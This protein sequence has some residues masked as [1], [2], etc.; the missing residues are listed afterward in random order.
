MEA[1]GALKC[2]A[3]VEIGPAPILTTLGQECLGS[4]SATWCASLR[5]GRDDWEQLFDCVMTL[6][7]LGVPIDMAGLEAG[8]PRRRLSLPTYQ[9]QRERYWFNARPPQDISRENEAVG[10][11]PLLGLQLLSPLPQAQFQARLS[12]VTPSFINDHQVNGTVLLP[13]T[14]SLEMARAAARAVF[15]PGSHVVEDLVLRQAMIF[16]GE[17]RRVVQ[18]TVEP[19]EK[20]AS[21][22]RI[23]STPEGSNADWTLHFEGQLRDGAQVTFPEQYE[24]LAAIESRCSA[25]MSAEPI[26]ATVREQGFEFGH[27][28]RVLRT[29]QKGIGEALG[30]V[31]LQTE[32]SREAEAYNIHPVLLDGC[33]QTIAAAL[34]SAKQEADRNA[35]YLPVGVHRFRIFSKPGISCRSHAVVEET[36]RQGVTA[37]RA[38]VRLYH[39]NGELLA[40]LEGIELQRVDP[41]ALQRMAARRG[42]QPM[43]VRRWEPAALASRTEVES[44]QS[45]FVILSDRS[46]IG[47]GLASLLKE[48]GNRCLLWE[49]H[50]VLATT[51]KAADM[52]L[53]CRQW[54]EEFGNKFGVVD[55]RWLDTTE[56]QGS[57]DQPLET[58][59][60]GTL[61]VL[62]AMLADLSDAQPR[63]W[64]VTRGGQPAGEVGS[65]LSPWQSAAWG[66]GWSAALEHPEFRHVRIDLDPAVNSD[67]IAALAAE[68]SQDGAEDQVALRS[69]QRLVARLVRHTEPKEGVV[70]LVKD[71][72]QLVARQKGAI[73]GLETV[74]AVRRAPESGE[75]EIR[76]EASGLNFRDV[77]NALDLYPGDP[78]P[79]GGECVGTVICVGPGVTEFSEGDR[80]MAM[81][82]GCFASHVIARR[83]L[84]HRIPPGFTSIEAAALPIAYL[85]ATYTLDHLAQL[86]AGERILI[87]AGA[88]GVGM[89]AIQIALRSGAEIFATA[90]SPAKR[91]RLRA[92]GVHHVLDSRSVDFADEILALTDGRGVD[93][94]LNSL[95]GPFIDASF[96]ATALG[97]RFVE[98]GKRGIWTPDQVERLGRKIRYHIVDVGTA[99]DEDPALIGKLFA[100]IFDEV[101][102][103]TL[104][105]LP[106]TVFPLSDVSAAFRHMMQARQVGKIVVTH[107]SAPAS[108]PTLVRE[109]GTY[110]VTGGLS[111]LGL[112]VAQWL[113]ERGAKHLVLVGRRG[114]TDEAKMALA[115]MR[116]G[117]ATVETVKLDVADAPAVETF[118]DTLR[119]KSPPLRGVLHAAG[120][121]DDGAIISQGW[122][123]FAAV[124]RSKATGTQILDRLTRK[125]P[126][127]WFVMFSSAASIV[128]SPGQA[129]YAA[130][131]T[132]L[133]VV[134]HERRRLGR[135]AQSINWG[136]W[137]EVGLSAGESMQE[138]VRMGGLNPMT[139]R[140]G[141][142]ALETAMASNAIQVG[143]LNADWP[144]LIGR[145]NV[146]GTPPYFAALVGTKTETSVKTANTPGT[147]GQNLRELVAAAS[148]S[149]R[150]GVVRNFV[151]D[152]SLHVLGQKDKK[153]LDDQTPLRDLGLDSLLA[154]ELR[155]ALGRSLGTGLPAT[156]LFD[157][158]TVNA[159]TNFLWTEV[160]GGSNKEE[161]GARASD[162]APTGS[163]VL[164]NVTEMSDEEVERLLAAKQ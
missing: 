31:E 118:L 14:A 6:H 29:I 140:Q 41:G 143:L 90:G 125:D 142:S 162:E 154:V 46:G 145:R 16:D 117:G 158:S 135:P 112:K 36:A 89:A 149:R 156:L 146:E 123:R 127:D 40:E 10:V 5:R 91:S 38:S 70:P 124:L 74:S 144:K 56:W 49:P 73:D 161:P 147:A 1:L 62:Q 129:N 66:L 81:A 137:Q 115:A 60:S 13:G 63:L 7:T 20:G 80:V 114:F 11:H 130:A 17:A 163:A 122:G 28:F 87:H 34:P 102:A 151:R 157:Y 33:V 64:T 99:S 110:L 2:D 52:S 68:L 160:L 75:I 54:R 71:C 72:Y 108:A 37:F 121:I 3:I 139:P 120:T 12:A 82:P 21:R 104:P 59:V 9:F 85:T 79:L 22:F 111:G 18:T 107:S 88:G 26:Y 84:A 133:D 134:A 152:C 96:K 8:Q 103:G 159:L 126:L 19:A 101:A 141:L 105:G 150:R 43:H 92:L 109:D 131:N 138:R 98:I 119:A 50:E 24:S 32:T 164:V 30:E 76:V 116:S 4:E 128:G 55:L 35:L 51:D 155:N 148:P 61:A 132:I 83:E 69:G 23:Q 100:R 39:P 45:A 95:S 97:G 113:A 93:V 47:A 58:P 77:L 57:A 94:V 86:K 65:P 67:E 44:R 42:V 153:I 53:R 136:A 15:G 106:V 27:H 48:R 78:G 25:P